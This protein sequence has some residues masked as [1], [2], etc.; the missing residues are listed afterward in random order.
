MAQELLAQLKDGS[1]VCRRC[2][3]L[4]RRVINIRQRLFKMAR[5]LMRQLKIRAVPKYSPLPNLGFKPTGHPQVVCGETLCICIGDTEA[6]TT[7]IFTLVMQNGWDGVKFE[8]K[9]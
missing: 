6:T 7:R 2:W 5:S 3:H 8:V 9:L 4:S 1:A